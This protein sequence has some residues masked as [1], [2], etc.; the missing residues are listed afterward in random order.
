MADNE[1][2][3]SAAT[4]RRRRTKKEKDLLQNKSNQDNL[5]S[6]IMTLENINKNHFREINKIIKSRINELLDILKG[7]DQKFSLSVRAANAISMLDRMTQDKAMKSHIRT[8]LWQVVSNL[9]GIR[10]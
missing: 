2:K 4:P 1:K 9:E 3:S 10:E 6:A 7:D 5:A 8:M